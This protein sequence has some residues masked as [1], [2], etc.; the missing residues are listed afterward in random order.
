MP[1]QVKV[2]VDPEGKVTMEV[3][4]VVGTSCEKYTDAVKRALGGKVESEKEKA[5]YYEVPVAQTDSVW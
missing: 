4:G 3:N 2:I 5:S 1:A